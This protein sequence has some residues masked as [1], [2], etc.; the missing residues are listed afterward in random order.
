MNWEKRQYAG[1]LNASNKDESVTCCGWVDTTETV[2]LIIYT[3]PEMSKALF[4]LYSIKIKNQTFIK[5]AQQL[6]SEDCISTNNM[7]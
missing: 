2:T 4:R 6:R 3:L 1:D 7:S 5:Q